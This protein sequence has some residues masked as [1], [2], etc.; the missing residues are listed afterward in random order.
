[1]ATILFKS[2]F[3]LVLVTVV[4]ANP[5]QIVGGSAA[6][7]DDIHILARDAA[8]QTCTDWKAH[9]TAAQI[10][11]NSAN[12]AA[13]CKNK[14]GDYISTSVPLGNCV[15]NDGGKLHCR[16]GGRAGETC[17]LSDLVQSGSSVFIR[18]QCANGIGGIFKVLFVFVLAS[19]AYAAALDERAVVETDAKAGTDAIEPIPLDGAGRTCINW[20]IVPNTADVSALCQNTQGTFIS[21]ILS[22]SNCL[23]NDL[24]NLHCRGSGGA[25]AT[26]VFSNLFQS[27]SSVL[28]SSH[29]ANGGGGF[30]DTINF[31]LDTCLT[32]SN[33]NLGC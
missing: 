10:V 3:V 2:F 11:P 29:C 17:G 28:I 18:S 33:G 27:G 6:N 13:R 21:T 31:N 24:G 32:N 25:G 9:E 19:V 5:V 22:L 12:I 20:Q 14:N 1:M 30:V 23:A 8:G 16:A 4:C 26:C 15:A 7:T